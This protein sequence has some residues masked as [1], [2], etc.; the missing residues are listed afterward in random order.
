[1]SLQSY[2][3]SAMIITAKNITSSSLLP[4]IPRLLGKPTY[5]HIYELNKILSDNEGSIQST[6]GCGGH[7][8]LGLI[9]PTSGLHTRDRPL[10]HSTR[11]SATQSSLPSRISHRPSTP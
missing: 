5:K 7:D 9:I 11:Q 4:A 8:L 3:L 10:L 1:M 2:H 6:L